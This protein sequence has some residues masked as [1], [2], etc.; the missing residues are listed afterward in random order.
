M[1]EKQIQDI[2]DQVI[3]ALQH[4]AP[5]EP[6]VFANIA[7]LTPFAALTAA[8]VAAVVGYKNL[9]QQQRALKESVKSNAR[10]LNQK[11]QAD[12][13]SEW[14]K[15]TQWALEAAASDDPRMYA[16]GA[17]MLDLLAQSELAGPK[18]KELLDAVWEG[19]DTEMQDE[20]IEQLIKDASEQEDLTYEELLSLMSFGPED[21]AALEHLKEQA[22]NISVEDMENVLRHYRAIND[23]EDEQE[24]LDDPEPSEPPGGFGGLPG[25]FRGLLG[26]F[27][28]PRATAPVD[29]SSSPDNN[30]KDS[31]EEEDGDYSQEVRS[32]A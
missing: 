4:L 1:D 32:E 18:D 9:N 30:M 10:S 12:A 7:A 3:A 25:R 11:R 8:I 23:Q 13:R 20:D 17:G 28:R 6:S 19:T 29:D 16:Y 5:A 14:W 21:V 15:R 2:A 24:V 26:R 27:R 22:K 31:K